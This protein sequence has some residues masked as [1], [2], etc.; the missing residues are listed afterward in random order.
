MIGG[1][2]NISAV[3]AATVAFY[4]KV[5]D[6]KAAI[7]TAYKYVLG[8]AST[9]SPR[10]NRNRALIHDHAASNCPITLLRRPHPASGVI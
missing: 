8:A 9:P 6:T 10:K 7:I 1:P 5:T 2:A 3:T 4:S